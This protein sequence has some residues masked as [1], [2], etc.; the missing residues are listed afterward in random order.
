MKC[1]IGF[2]FEVKSGSCI[3]CTS[4]AEC[5]LPTKDFNSRNIDIFFRFYQPTFTIFNE[6]NIEWNKK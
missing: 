3:P 5:D 6:D 2:F 4:C 1:K